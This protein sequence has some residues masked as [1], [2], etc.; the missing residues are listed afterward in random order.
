[1]KNK[2]I[3]IIPAR[4]GSKRIPHKNIKL[5]LGRPIIQYSIEAAI[6]SNLF[7]EVMVSTD[8]NEIADISKKFGAKVPFM[9]SET[10]ANDYAGLADVIEEVIL[11]YK[12]KENLEFKFICC[13]LSTAP[14]IKPTILKQAFNMLIND[15]FDSVF[16]IVKFSYP[17]QR[18]FKV[19]NGRVCMVWPE[20]LIKRSQDLMTT[21]HDSGQF[22]WLK[23]NKFLEEKKLF[24]NNSG[25]IIFS[26]IESHD[27]D[28]EGDWKIAEMKYKL[29]K[30]N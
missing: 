3:A 22:Y 19:I 1:M 16:P 29:I 2:C 21:Y 17:I 5:F 23:T 28:T 7:D 18:A 26:E 14:F 24:S 27:I 15:N 20:N 10:T 6:K 4:G 30:N 25:A 8:D 13:I 11:N 9:R 12:E